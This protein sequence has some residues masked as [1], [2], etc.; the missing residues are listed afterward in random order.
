MIEQLIY[1]ILQ[2]TKEIAGFYYQLILL[3]MDPAAPTSVNYQQLAEQIHKP[4]FNINLELSQKM[5]LLTTRQRA[6]QTAG[7]LREIITAVPHDT[8]LLTH[9]NILFDPIL[10]QDPLRLLQ[11]LSRHKIIIAIWE[12][13]IQGQYLTY[14]TPDHPEYRRYPTKELIIIEFQP[15]AGSELAGGSKI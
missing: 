5:L 4:S 8:V 3:V 7:L 9:M 12:G 11:N 14:A 1:Q 13:Q 15:S 2:K 6:L 10:R